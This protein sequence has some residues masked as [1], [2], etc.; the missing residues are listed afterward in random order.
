M[1]AGR[2]K[3]LYV[4]PESLNKEDNLEFFKSF[5]ISFY[6]IDEAHC[7]SEWGHD[8]RPEYRNIRPTINKIGAAPVIALTA[9]ATDKVRTDIK[10]SLGIVNAREFKSSFNRPNLYYEVRQKTKDIDKQIIKFI[11]HNAGKSG[12]VYCISRKKVEELAA[13]LQVNDIKAAPYHAG[14]DSATRSQTQDDFLMERIDVIV[15]TIAFGMGIDKPD[16]R[17]V[18]HYDIPKSLEGYY[19]ETGRAGRDGG[20]GICIAFY[21]YQDL[22]KLE[23]FMEGK[24]VAEQ[25]IGKQLLQE[26]AAYA[27][28]CVCRRKLL[29]H[30]FGE[31][32]HQEN[33]G[34]CDNCLH[35]K[36]KREGK[37]ALLIILK[38]VVAI[39]EA[40]Q[41]PYLIDFVKGR[42]TDE[43]VSHK[44]DQLEEFGSGEDEDP[45]IWNPVIR[46][47]LIAGYLDKEV[48]NYGVLK[49][50]PAG[51]KFI[52]NPTSFMIVEDNDFSEQYEEEGGDRSGAALDPE[53]YSMLKDL[54]KKVAKKQGLPGYVIFQDVS[55]EQMATMYPI[56]IE[57]LQNIQ[58]VGIGKA[59]RYGREFCELIKRHCEENDIERPEELR[60]RTV[61]KKSMLKVKIIQSIDRQIPL[62]D[63]A[64]A[65]GLEFEE[66]LDE[67]EAIVYS[68]TKLNIDYF[69]DDV[70][71][72]DH[73]DD[74][75]E[76]FRESETGDI[77]TAL[78]ELGDDSTENDIRLVRIKF[79]SEMGN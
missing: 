37:D 13:V 60:V 52:K 32:Y 62:D 31:E 67:I 33:C 22:Q 6:A 34:N 64:S 48:E 69:L 51:R 78:E 10:K 26:T 61:A 73:I 77:E 21:A 74:I 16:V 1:H 5:K 40:F 45:K 19:Q 9:T 30:Y 8:F 27:E 42:S 63:I 50:T 68:G 3:L 43:I 53:L 79:L 29:L 44:H 35:P 14:L 17:F 24:P 4:A 54:R 57:E 36:E 39:K 38:A 56:T 71:D 7:I 41:Q 72:A 20:E 18:I 66:L 15:A 46:Q 2:T 49:I 47:A 28:S 12:I 70:M 65:Q 58:G 76:Y 25:D 55:L 23:K 59:K 75:Y 11:K